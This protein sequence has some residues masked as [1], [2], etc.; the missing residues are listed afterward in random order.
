MPNVA[1]VGDA[2]TNHTPCD[3]P[4]CQTGS[5]NVLANHISV[6]RVGDSNTDHG[7]ILCIPH[8]TNLTSGSPDVYVNN[9]PI[10]RIGD[11]Y[12]CGVKVN[13]GSPNVI[14]NS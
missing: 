10:A 11:D 3:S 14:A 9:Q 7:Y 2:V 5:Q 13:S 6:H 4:Q 8:S 1:R 12:S